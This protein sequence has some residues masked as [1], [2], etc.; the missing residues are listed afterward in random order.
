MMDSV[1]LLTPSHQLRTSKAWHLIAATEMGQLWRKDASCRVAHWDVLQAGDASTLEALAATLQNASRRNAVVVRAQPP[2]DKKTNLRRRGDVFTAAA[3]RWICIDI[4]DVS[5]E[6]CPTLEVLIAMHLP[7]CFHGA[8]YVAQLSSS[9]GMK[10]VGE[11][12]YTVADG[13]WK[14]HLW[15]LTEEAHEDAVLRAFLKDQ[16]P[17]VDWRTLVSVQPHYISDPEWFNGEHQVTDPTSEQRWSVSDGPRVA[18]KGTLD[19]WVAKNQDRGRKHVST[20][21]KGRHMVGQELPSHHK[22]WCADALERFGQNALAV[23]VQTVE[24]SS[25]KD[26][27]HRSLCTGGQLLGGLLVDSRTGLTRDAVV[28]ALVGA[29]NGRKG[30]RDAARAVQWGLDHHFNRMDELE[31]AGRQPAVERQSDQDWWEGGNIHYHHRLNPSSLVEGRYLPKL[32]PHSNTVYVKAPQGSGKTE[33]V[34][35]VALPHFREEHADSRI[36]YVVH[37]RSMARAAADRLGLPCYMDTQGA[38]KHDCVVSVDSLHRVRLD[39]DTQLI[40][41]LDEVE[42]VIH[43]LTLSGTMNGEQK[44]RAHNAWLSVLSHAVA[45]ICMDADLG[46]LTL[47]EVAAH[48]PPHLSGPGRGH[49]IEVPQ[50]GVEWSYVVCQ[51]KEW[52]ESQ[53]L[54]AYESGE[55]VAVAC[56]SRK[57]AEALAL[58]L[59][60]VRGNVG[61][62]TSKTIITDEGRV[63]QLNPSEWAAGKDAI[64]YSPT[65]GTA[66]SI[67]TPGFSRIYAFGSRNVGTAMDLLQAAHRVRNPSN[68]EILI[69][70]PQ[71]GVERTTEPDEIAQE[72]IAMASRTRTLITQHLPGVQVPT[73]FTP[74]DNKMASR[75]GRVVGHAREW[76]AQGCDLYKAVVNLLRA[77]SLRYTELSAKLTQEEAMLNREENKA[78]REQVA[79]DWAATVAAA[80]EMSVKDAERM[81]D[82]A[83]LEEAAAAEKALIQDFYGECSEDTIKADDDGRLRSQARAYSDLKLALQDRLQ[84]LAFTD[85]PS[86]GEDQ[87]V[88]AMRHRYMKAVSVRYALVAAG[89]G[90]LEG[91]DLDMD[92]LCTWALRNAEIL[93]MLGNP[94]RAD[95]SKRTALWLSNLLRRYGLKLTSQRKQ[96]DGVRVRTY[97]VSQE[98]LDLMND[99]SKNYHAR[100]SDPGPAYT[101]KA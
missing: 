26:A 88:T 86:V 37:R 97:R 34:G 14:V 20:A 25:S 15:F 51:N 67:T 35:K 21:S 28:N 96:V 18:L 8:G 1:T 39:E 64:V 13:A 43:H 78:A 77:R 36:L 85:A 99:V 41:V 30:A 90:D 17:M 91:D 38:L 4:D 66:V 101:E 79:A 2:A 48:A 27:L 54:Q 75:Y 47:Q 73:G 23:A 32:K 29:C 71:G 52:L 72:V 33:W 58:R 53:L 80:E 95:I 44:L 70:A 31:A 10:S 83:T 45:L 82:A 61:L 76:G 94:V 92:R 5:K 93:S 57:Q 63:A 60:N 12:V 81:N 68:R 74:T 55:R 56:Q 50:G 22:Y 7:A 16:C 49:L 65:W 24:R 11:D 59:E 62:V 46:S 69:H 6:Q 98:S 9:A 89:D 42:Q 100:R 40:L 84:T 87:A 3:R 19:S